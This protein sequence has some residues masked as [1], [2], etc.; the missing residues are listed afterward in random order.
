[1]MSSSGDFG[2]P[3]PT[4]DGAGTAAGSEL[5]RRLAGLPAPEAQRMLTGLVTELAA[6]A[7]RRPPGEPVAAD[8]TFFETGFDSLTAVELHSR[9]VAATGLA[10][11]VTLAFDYPTP[12]ALARHLHAELLGLA[13][14][15][16]DIDAAVGHADELIAIV[17]MACR[18][19]GGVRSSEALWRLVESEADAIGE[20]PADRGWDL[21]A[22]YS[23]DPDQPGTSYTRHG[24]FL[25]DAAEFDADFFGIN[26]REALAMDAQ[27]RLVLETSWEALERAGI[28]PETLREQRVGVFVGAETQ[29]YGPR[30]QDADGLEGYL[31][32]GNAASVASGRVSYTL[33][34]QGPALTIDT[35][36][37]SSLVA[38]HLAA[39]ALRQGEC[40]MALA[41]GVAVMASPASFVAFSRQR[42]LAADGRCKPFAAAADGTGW[43][44]GVGMLLVERLSSAQA[45]GRRILAV[46]RG[47]AVNQDGASNGL[48]APN[49]PSQQRVIRQA[50]ANAR[51]EAADVDAVEAHGTGTMLGDPVEAQALLATYGRDRAGT[52]LWLGSLKSNIGHAQAAAGVGGVIKMVQAIQHGL[53]P[54]TLHVDEPTPH[55]DWSAGTVRLLT[56]AQPWPETDRPR[57]AAVSSFGMSGTNVHLI[58]EAPPT[59]EPAAA[60][61]EPGTPAAGVFA[62]PVSGRTP[63]ALA[64]QAAN[65]LGRLDEPDADLADLGFSLATT[66]TH[67]AHRAVVFGADREQVARGLA[68]LAAGDPSAQVVTGAVA[69]GRTAFLFTGQGSQRVAMGRELYATQ[70]VFATAFDEAGWYLDLQLDRP[71]ADALADEELLG[72][73][74]YAQPTI[75]AVEVALL[76]LVRHW[77]LTPDVLVGHSIGEIAVAYAAG[78]LSLAD[79]AALVGARGRLMQALPA[80]GAMLAVQA[81]ESDVHAAF[82]DVDIAAVNGPDA[83]VVSGSEAEIGRVAAVAAERG[84]KT[85]RLRTSH[86]F[87]SRLMEPMLAEFRRV[88]RF[89]TFREPKLPIVST[90]T[91]RLV[92]SG[93][94]SDPEYWVEQVRSPV[95][96]ADALAALDG[97]TNYVELGPDAVLTALARQAAPEAVCVPLLRR[98]RDEAAT[99]I[100]ALAALHVHGATVDWPALFPHARVV[101]LP[102]Y[103][104][105]RQHFWLENGPARPGASD[106]GD[107]GFWA[108]VDR[109]DLP[110]LAAE[111]G[112]DTAA[113]AGVLPALVS[114]RTRSRERSLIDGWRYRI[115]W[116][117]VTDLAEAVPRGTWALVGDDALGLAEALT[118]MGAE[119]VVVP[120]GDRADLAVRLG[121]LAPAGVLVLPSAALAGVLAVV[122]ALADI[123]SGAPLWLVT[124]GAV[125]AGRADGAPDVAQ[126]AKWGLGRVI[127]LEH[128][129]RW[130]GLL[131]LPETLDARAVTRLGAVLAGGLGVEDQVVVRSGGVLVRRLGHAPASVAPAW[132]PRGTVLVTGGTGGLGAEVARW[133]AANGAERLVLVS[134]RGVDAPGAEALLAEL[135]NAEVHACDLADRSAVEALLAV[136]GTVDAVV[137]AAGVGEDAELADAD[138]AHLNRV[139]SGKV[140]GALHLDAL[141]GDVDAFVVFSSISGAWGSRG[142]AAYGAANAALD[143]LVERRR[144]AGRP[145]TAIA[146]GP[147]ARI[148]MAAD[149]GETELLRRQGLPPL[150]P[151]QAIAALAGAVGA[152]DSTITVADVRWA[153]FVPLF[154]AARAR[155]L[156]DDLVEA[157]VPAVAGTVFS[158]FGQRLAGLAVGD[159]E[160]LVVE[161]VRTHVA[162]VLG[163]ASSEAVA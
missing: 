90:V 46:I 138:A 149:Q 91:G 104:F 114:W 45:A 61:P 155:P 139:L 94:W 5:R 141:V 126:A 69:P 37:S 87:H 39:Q 125:A 85:T 19:P 23:A 160:R 136:V 54:K 156:F 119:V 134:R 132:R 71:L 34:L 137:H 28:P 70:P 49:G 103:E 29:E 10:L 101:D 140:D 44:E 152:G 51:L 16:I 113:V 105:Q 82:P 42:G 66:R 41:G 25:Y 24:G 150:A 50:L 131:D 115:T 78:V 135:P 142:Q 9:L 96:F 108:A 144:A 11:P 60:A 92:E 77:G 112:V 27:Q 65:L 110:A 67:F 89:L 154:A 130:G 123:E 133:A 162:A 80:G 117:P 157:E 53:L 33:G 73:T 48:T 15:R 40:E 106:P 88:L 161:V 95:R 64:G 109:A 57:R 63:E 20:F 7:L 59:G 147:W 146:W 62:L 76:A 111:L 30:L 68:A 35:A 98:D 158:T 31:L 74:E 1:M 32:T 8:G 43:A 21:D 83:V 86:A 127:G 56:E 148:G 52:P 163:H 47:S 13:P 14:E 121:E 116:K 102:T 122:Q 97:V 145:G 151:A 58:L 3:T 124:R 22:L 81:G 55:V 128:P 84:W 143:A 12:A 99:A 36:C 2:A 153:E 118:G 79:A 129:E 18:F 159:R 6:A 100:A 26:P 107:A 75:F 38:L 93:Q 17:G 72:R 4:G 120:V